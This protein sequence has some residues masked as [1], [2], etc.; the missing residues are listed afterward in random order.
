MIIHYNLDNFKNISN[1][2]ITMGSFDGVHVGHKKIIENIIASAAKLNGESVLFSF[3]PHPRQVLFANT[4]SHKCLNT[5]Q[6]KIDLLKKTPIDHIIFFPFSIEFSKI[7]SKDFVLNYLVEKIHVKKIII[8]YDYHF[9]KNR[10][11]NYDDL[12]QFGQNYG[13][14][15]EQIKAFDINSIAVSS[16]KT[17]NALNVG[18]IKLANTYLGY[19][20]PISGKVISGNQI[21]RQLGFPTA[22]IQISD[23]CKLIP[24][25]GVYAAKIEINGR[26]YKGMVN[27][28]IRPTLN[29][30]DISIE[31]N[32]FDFNEDVY[33]KLITIR[34]I[35]RIRNEIKFPDLDALA[36]Q[37]I[38][39]KMETLNILDK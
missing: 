20:Y 7:S 32:I 15:V 5:Q 27:I 8:G 25:N 35:D 23:P 39:D 14:E 29:L 28:G 21:G 6:E 16:T 10:E 24:A 31:A 33:D 4:Y 26:I 22:N 1:P 2:V 3:Y 9:G 38:K 19:E 12:Y 37:L 11:G 30:K 18:N 17:R 34:F 36:S 13:F